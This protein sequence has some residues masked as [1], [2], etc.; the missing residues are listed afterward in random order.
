M[1]L[2]IVGR[3]DGRSSKHA[4]AIFRCSSS[5]SSKAGSSTSS[6]GSNRSASFDFECCLTHPTRLLSSPKSVES[7]GGFPV[8]S[9]SNTTP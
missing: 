9:S 8:S 6:T 7:V 2:S 1:T 3:L 4:Q 5:S